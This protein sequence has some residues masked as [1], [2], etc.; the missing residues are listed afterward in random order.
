M[1]YLTMIAKSLVEEETLGE[2]N[3]CRAKEDGINLRKDCSL[4]ITLHAY[5]AYPYTEDGLIES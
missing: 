4:I 5:N 2:I 3:L 1:Y